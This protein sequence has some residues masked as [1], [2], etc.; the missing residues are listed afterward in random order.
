MLKIGKKILYPN[1]KTIEILPEKSKILDS[2]ILDNGTC[3]II[4]SY[5]TEPGAI[6][7][8][9]EKSV[10]GYYNSSNDQEAIVPLEPKLCQFDMAWIGTCGENGYFVHSGEFRGN[11]APP[12]YAVK[13]EIYCE[14]HLGIKCSNPGCDNQACGECD[15]ASSLVCGAP[16][17]AECG[18]HFSCYPK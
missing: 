10:C 4:Y 9:P 3:I 17:C 1:E 16:Y 8:N 5:E 6:V 11:M 15:C 14:H 18:Q 12:I 13:G 2:R 7:T